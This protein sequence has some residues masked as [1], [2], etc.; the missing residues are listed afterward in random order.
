MP[1]SVV[2]MS[3]TNPV[4][5]VSRISCVVLGVLA[6][7]IK[8]NSNAHLLGLVSRELLTVTVFYHRPVSGN[9]AVQPLTKQ[10]F[11]LGG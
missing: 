2:Q 5:C 10:L 4:Q 6:N 8:K 1:A 7:Y 9:E 11:L 3:A